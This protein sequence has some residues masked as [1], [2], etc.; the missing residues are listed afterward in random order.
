MRASAVFIL[1]S[2]LTAGASAQVH[3]CTDAAGKTTFSD[4]PC[5]TTAKSAKQVL[6][7]GATDSPADP[8]AAQRNLESIER[9]RQLQQDLV[10]SSIQQSQGV[11]G[12]VSLNPGRAATA[13]ASTAPADSEQCETY[14]TR[15][16]CYGGE[17]GR[18]PKWSPTRGYYG[19][20]GPADQQYEVDRRVRAAQPPGQM[21]NCDAAG[22][23]GSQNGV[24]YN[25]VAGGNLSGTNGSF[26]TRGAGNTFSCN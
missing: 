16:G 19:S 9:S 11:G 21:V 3:R 25:R 20:G 14:G 7:R 13:T 24:R 10:D 1:A 2:M 4:A 17:R 15:K 23:W 12:P 18:N 6:G 22:C 8:Y 5:S 26:C